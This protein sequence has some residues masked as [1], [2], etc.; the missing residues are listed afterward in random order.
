M[1]K[2]F[3]SLDGHGLKMLAEGGVEVAIISGRS[4]SALALR[5]KNLG[6]SELHMG[7]HDKRACLL[8]LLTQKNIPPAQA[9]YMGDDVVDLPVLRIC[10]FSAAPADAHPFVIAHVLW[11]SGKCGGFGAVRE[12]SDFILD[13]Q[14]K[15]DALHAAYL[16]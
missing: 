3:H 14:G 7:V 13:A 12:L 4:S 9:G 10:G 5:A 1:L 8:S 15:L 2:A 11:V 16:G 6:I